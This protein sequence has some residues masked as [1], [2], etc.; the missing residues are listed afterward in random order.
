MSNG[1]IPRRVTGKLKDEFSRLSPFGPSVTE[2][3]RARILAT[4]ARIIDGSFEIYRGPIKDNNG[5]LAIPAGTTL[6]IEDVELD[7]MNWLVEGTLGR[8]Q[9]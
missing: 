7:K 3:M 1:T 9:F 8:A 2:P 4:K 5:N 6:E